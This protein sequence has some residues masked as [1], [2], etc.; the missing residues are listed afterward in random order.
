LN[1][2][3]KAKI[4][5]L[6]PL[7]PQPEIIKAAA[8]IIQ[9]GG[10]IC[11]PTRCLYGLGADALKPDAAEKVFQVKERPHHKPILVL[12][13]HRDDLKRL[14]KS[15]PPEAVRIMDSFWPGRVTLIFEAKSGLPAALTAGTGKIGLRLPGHPAAFALVSA[16]KNPITGTSA[17]LSGGKSCSKVGELEPVL[18]AKLDLILDAGALKGGVGSTVVDVTA[19]PPKILREGE[20]LGKDIFGPP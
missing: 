18:A 13:K 9:R 1:V 5:T 11:F 7:R 19:S 15:V 2:E 14:V 16:L 12:I 8:R 20:I 3:E 4:L 17:N 10:I 6:E